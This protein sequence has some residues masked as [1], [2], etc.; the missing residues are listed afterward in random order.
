MPSVQSY[1]LTWFLWFTAKSTCQSE[2]NLNK[3]VRRRNQDPAPPKKLY[4]QFKID[5]SSKHGYIV[6]TLSPKLA[7]PTASLL[8]LHGGGFIFN[9]TRQHWGLVAAISKRVNATVTVPIYPLAPESN[10][11]DIY[12]VVRPLYNEL[13]AA[14]TSEKPFWCG[15][16]SAG[17]TMTLALTREATDNGSPCPTRMLLISPCVDYNCTNSDLLDAA[18]KDPW[19]DVPGIK[20]MTRLV[21]PDL[22]TTDARL[23][24]IYGNL[25]GFPPMVVF[26]GGADL[27]TPD[28]KKFVESA[29][30][31]GNMVKFYLVD[32]M[33]H[34]WPVMPIPEAKVAIEQM[35]E[36]LLQS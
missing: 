18:K 19:L 2:E 4:E 16:D 29:K 15:G 31:Q 11:L 5:E 23:S 7:E 12:K 3:A 34:I 21:C 6:Y 35:A 32:K 22:D 1:L 28:T 27:L 10:L 20:E 8:Y 30:E 9:M 26:A 13:A 33:V 14:A 36:W 24:P 25:K 17:G